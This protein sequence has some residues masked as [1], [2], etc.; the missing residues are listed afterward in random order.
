MARSIF[1]ETTRPGAAWMGW[2]AM[3]AHTHHPLAAHAPALDAD[4]GALGG[5]LDRF[6]VLR[7]GFGRGPGS[8]HGA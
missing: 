5:L 8:G 4:G 2:L 6:L 7:V 3:P 1:G